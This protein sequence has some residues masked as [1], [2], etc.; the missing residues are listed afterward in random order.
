MIKEEKC[1]NPW[2]EEECTSTDIEVYIWYKNKKVPICREC[3]V[4]IAENE[5]DWDETNEME[6]KE[7]EE[8]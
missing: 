5:I 1:K 6:E 7:D 3:W 8:E 2:K 4:E